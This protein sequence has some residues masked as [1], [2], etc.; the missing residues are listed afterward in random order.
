MTLDIRSFPIKAWKERT[1]TSK[2]NVTWSEF[3]NFL[4]MLKMFLEEYKF[5]KDLIKLP[6]LSLRLKIFIIIL[7]SCV[8]E[9]SKR[10]RNPEILWTN[11]FSLTL[12]IK[13]H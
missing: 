3:L 7:C 5:S 2:E 6:M 12:T 4:L 11:W 1:S 10:I 9:R 8:M 13:D